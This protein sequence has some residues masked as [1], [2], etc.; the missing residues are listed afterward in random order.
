MSARLSAYDRAQLAD[1]IELAGSAEAVL[2]AVDELELL[3]G[4]RP[5]LFETVNMILER[6][7]EGALAEF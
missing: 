7:R 6:K 1:L 2:E 5:T 4:R 3:K